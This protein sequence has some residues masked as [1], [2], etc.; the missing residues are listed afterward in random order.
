[1]EESYQHNDIKKGKVD[2]VQDLCTINLVEADFNF[3]KKLLAKDA[4]RCAK[5]NKLFLQE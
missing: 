4:I 2:K 1:M 5:V 3:N